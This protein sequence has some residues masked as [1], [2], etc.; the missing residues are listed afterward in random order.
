MMSKMLALH[1]ISKQAT[2][3]VFQQTIIKRFLKK[4]VQQRYAQD[5]NIPVHLKRGFS[6]KA[7]LFL[8]AALTAVGVVSGMYTLIGMAFSSKK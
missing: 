8:T 5:E 4:E 7:L 1:A 3:P 6:D 2:K